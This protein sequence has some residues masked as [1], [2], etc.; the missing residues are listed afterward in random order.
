[1]E[2]NFKKKRIID[3]P[4][5]DWVQKQPCLVSK[6]WDETVAPH[7]VYG[8]GMGAKCDD[9]DTVPLRYVLHDK[10]ASNLSVHSMNKEP[11]EEYHGVDFEE[12]IKRLQAL[13]ISQ[14]YKLKT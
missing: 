6:F 13:Y 7:H 5:L 2:T 1:M 9:K 4:Y 14:G 11:F 8:A 12:E 3:K 10:G